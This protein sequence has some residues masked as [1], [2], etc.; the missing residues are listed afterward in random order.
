ME[1]LPGMHADGGGLYL[2]VTVDGTKNWVYRYML[3]GHPRWMGLGPLH[4]I[5]L[6]EGGTEPLSVEDSATMVLIP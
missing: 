5:G 3:H 2:R 1:K 6:A 4:I